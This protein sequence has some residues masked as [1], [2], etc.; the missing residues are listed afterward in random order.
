MFF[1][2]TRLADAPLMAAAVVAACRVNGWVNGVDADR[3]I[4]QLGVNIGSA[5]THLEFAMNIELDEAAVQDISDDA[6]E[7]AA[8]GAQ[9][10]DC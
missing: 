7:L 4:D 9:R 10:G 3:K 8:G 1:K 2:H 5:P 6:L